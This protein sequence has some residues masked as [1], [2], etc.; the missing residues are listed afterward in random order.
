[1]KGDILYQPSACP[2]AIYDLMKKCWNID[3]HKRPEFD[4]IKNFLSNLHIP[5]MEV[6]ADYNGENF[7]FQK[8]SHV[9]FIGEKYV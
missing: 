6:E 2:N 3:Y 1:M 5:I 9:I 4:K 7:Y 8:G